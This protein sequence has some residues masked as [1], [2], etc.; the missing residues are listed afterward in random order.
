MSSRML[1]HD[2]DEHSSSSPMKSLSFAGR[3]ASHASGATSGRS[4]RE[5][6]GE[7]VIVSGG[8]AGRLGGGGGGGHAA[9]ASSS[10]LASGLNRLPSRDG[11]GGGVGI[12]PARF[13]SRPK[14]GV[15]PSSCLGLRGFFDLTSV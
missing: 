15:R 2:A 11:L 8:H 6:S 3:C 5:D 9:A 7:V 4:I 12:V 10:G 1:K 14:D 13:R